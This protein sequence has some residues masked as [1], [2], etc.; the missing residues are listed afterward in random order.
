MDRRA[1]LGT[2]S[3]MVAPS[4]AHAQPAGRV[5]RISSIS[6]ELPAQGGAQRFWDA[7]AERLRELGWSPGRNVPSSTV[8][9]AWRAGGFPGSRKN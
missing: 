8:R 3:L 7:F 6:Q 1:F 5:Y 4:F 9:L 2:L